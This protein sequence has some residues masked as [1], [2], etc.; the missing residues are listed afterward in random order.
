[1][2]SELFKESKKK[3]II[4][5]LNTCFTELI[6]N[7]LEPAT[8]IEAS[9]GDTHCQVA[10]AGMEPRQ[11]VPSFQVHLIFLL[12]ITPCSRTFYSCSVSP[13]VPSIN[14]KLSAE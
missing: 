8:L 10:L 7:T 3:S 6:F 12:L 2:I 13:I 9:C 5:C 4:G 14:V 11:L 1:M